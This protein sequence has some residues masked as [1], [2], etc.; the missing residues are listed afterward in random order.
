M[1]E[2]QELAQLH[3]IHMPDPIGW[4]PLAPGWYGLLL[5]TLMALL[6]LVFF[7]SRHYFNG[8]AKRQALLILKTYQQQYPKELNGQ[9]SAARVSELLKRVALRYFPRAQVASLQG[10]AWVKFLNE[11]SKGLDFYSLRQELVEMPYRPVVESDL[12]PLFIMAEKWIKQRRGSCS[13]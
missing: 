12:Q 4:W 8:R 6:A 5:L 13:N 3:D 11:T 9:Q 7:F 2:P 1:A 10:E